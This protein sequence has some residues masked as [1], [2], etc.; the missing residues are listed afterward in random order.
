MK[1][2]VLCGFIF[3]HGEKDFSA[4]EVQL[5]NKD[6]DLIEQILMKYETSGSSVRNVWDCKFSDVMCEEY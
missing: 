1:D 4:F 6:K 5:E 3:C 2:P